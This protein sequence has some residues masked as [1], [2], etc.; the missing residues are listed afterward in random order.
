MS[1][2]P[3]SLYFVIGKSHYV[4]AAAAFFFPPVAI[5]LVTTLLPCTVSPHLS[6]KLFVL[7][8]STHLLGFDA[9]VTNLSCAVSIARRRFLN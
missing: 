5:P 6:Q 8:T 2:Q 9:R 1:L 4:N 7:H 3:C